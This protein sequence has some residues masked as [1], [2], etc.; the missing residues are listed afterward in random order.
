MD[1]D[2]S[3]LNIPGCV[4]TYLDSG[5]EIIF[6]DGVCN[7]C[8][9]TMQFILRRDK[10]KI[11]IYCPLQSKTGQWLLSALKKDPE[12][13]GS[14]YLLS[15]EQVLDKSSAAIAIFSQLGF[16]WTLAGGGSLLPKQLTDK[17][18]NLVAANRYRI[19]GKSDRCYVPEP[20][21][22]CRFLDEQTI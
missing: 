3:E 6:F 7:Y 19:F 5:K 18:Y 21:E 2:L 1:V 9:S 14:F 16:P 8:S 17:I 22:R 20:H 13:L 10:K 15:K 4:Q 12:N 11:F